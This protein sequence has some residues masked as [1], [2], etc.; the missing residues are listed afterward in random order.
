VVE[1]SIVVVCA[2]ALLYLILTTLVE[3]WASFGKSSRDAKGDD[4]GESDVR[5][6][7]VHASVKDR[8]A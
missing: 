1:F 8:A 4:S 7:A 2:G 5:S 6:T 3:G